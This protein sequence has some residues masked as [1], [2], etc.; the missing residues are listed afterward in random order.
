MKLSQQQVQFIDDNLRNSVPQFQSGIVESKDPS[1]MSVLFWNP[2][3]NAEISL[4][5]PYHA[6][7]KLTDTGIWSH[8]RSKWP[9][10]RI[11]HLGENV[12]L[13]SSLYSCTVCGKDIENS[14]HTA[15]DAP[16][17]SQLP[18]KYS[19]PFYLFKKSGV[20]RLA[21][22]F[23][24]NACL[25]GTSFLEIVASFKRM[26]GF[27][28]AIHGKGDEEV[29]NW[30]HQSPSNKLCEDIF[31]YDFDRRLKFYEDEMKQIQPKEI[32]IDHTFNTR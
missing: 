1:V 16:L 13:V 24:I 19:P 23:I 4:H 27:H 20:T 12:L 8:M 9:P 32:S 29:F 5:C 21:Y 14:T 22:E 11:Y 6:G 28:V 15:H 7:E 10:R 17:L 31:L 2:L 25:A 26:H 3:C 30:K 18:N